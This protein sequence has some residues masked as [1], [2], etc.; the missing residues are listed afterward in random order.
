MEWSSAA[1][2]EHRL[3]DLRQRSSADQA[4]DRL[5]DPEPRHVE[6]FLVDDRRDAR[7]EL[8]DKVA[9]EVQ[10]PEVVELEGADDLP[11]NGHPLLVQERL[12]V[13]REAG[14]NRLAC[15]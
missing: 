1:I 7:V 2:P 9:D 12:P 6:V 15:L 8:D 14:A 10:A 13:H 3:E 4:G 11:R 5:V